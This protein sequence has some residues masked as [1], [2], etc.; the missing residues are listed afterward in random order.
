MTVFD[1][2]AKRNADKL[3]AVRADGASIRYHLRMDGSEAGAIDV[4]ELFNGVSLAFNSIPQGTASWDD[5]EPL[6]LQIDWCLRGRFQLDDGIRLG[7]GELAVH[8]ERIRKRSMR[9][10]APLYTGFTIRISRSEGAEVLS[11][12]LSFDF[13]A[14]AQRLTG[15]SGCKIYAPD[16]SMKAL[17]VLEYRRTGTADAAASQSARTH[18]SCQR[19]PLSCPASRRLSAK[20]YY[21]IS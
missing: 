6:E 14:L 18:L 13:D 20:K 1:I 19:D 4:F 5:I 11:R 17:L 3:R 16:P 8:D 15:S 21:R 2:L 7:D 10:P 9:F 12:L